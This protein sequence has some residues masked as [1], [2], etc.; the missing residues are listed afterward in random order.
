MAAP[1]APH[2]SSI[3]R[4]AAREASVAAQQHVDAIVASSMA[5]KCSV[6]NRFKAAAMPGRQV[7]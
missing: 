3:V 1:P 5:Q 2:F 7:N 6:G 4:A